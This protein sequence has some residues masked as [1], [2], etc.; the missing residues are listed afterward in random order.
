MISIS[1]SKNIPSLFL[2]LIATVTFVLPV[3]AVA[4]DGV[5]EEIVVTAAKRQ[6]TLQEVP[7][8]VA[9]VAGEDIEKAQILDL[10]DLQ[11][12]VP[13]LKINTLQNS[14]NTNFFIRGFGNGANNPGIEPSVGVF[15]DG[16]YRSRS[17]AQIADLP[18]LERVEVL[19]GPQSTLF[20][21][22]ASAGVISVVTNTPSGEF[23]AK[24]S[25]TVGN[26]NQVSLK[27]VV[28]GGLT[29]NVA[30]ELSGSSNTRDGYVD[31]LVTGNELNDRDRQ[32]VR[33]QLAIAAGD[34][35]D[36]RIIADYDQ[37]EEKCCAVNNFFT[38][39]LE[40]FTNAVTGATINEND[41]LALTTYHNLD[42]NNEIENAGLSLQLDHD[43][44][45][46]TLTSISAFR[47]VDSG[48]VIDADFTAADYITNLI[49]TEIDT[50]T[51]ELRLAS[52]G[53]CEVDWM[54]GAYFFD[55]SIDY[56]NDLQ[57]GPQF[58]G[59]AD[60]LTAAGGSPN[61]LAGLETAL[62]L[63]VGQAFFPANGNVREVATMD[64]QAISLFGQ[65]DW[66]ISDQLTATLGMNYTEDEKE[67]TLA[68][69]D[70]DLFSSLDLVQIG[71]GAI[72]Q[73]LVAMGV[74]PAT[75]LA[76]AQALSTTPANPLLG[77]QPLQFLP[78]LQAYPN[79]VENGE[80]N[81]DELTYTARLA[82]DVNDSLNVYASYATG[83]KASSI[84]LSRDARPTA[85]DLAALQAAG[86]A[87]PNINSG[88]RFAS[89]EEATVI[90][91]G[92]KARLDRLSLNLA[93]FEQNI[94]NFQSNVFNGTGFNLANA[95]EQSTK[96]FEFDAT[97]YATDSLR[98]TFAGIL[99]DPVYDT[100]TAS[101][102]GDISG[103]TPAGIHETSLSLAATYDFEL[104]NG[105]TGFVSGD[106]QYEDKIPTNE[107]IPITI[108]SEE[109]NLLNLRVGFASQNG[110]AISLWGR[111]V[112]D[113]ETATTA[114]PTVAGTGGNF[115]YRS[116]PQTYG[117][118]ISKEF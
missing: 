8:A 95:E 91:L 13:S 98:I 69:V 107:G 33:G 56:S 29:D 64:N 48:Y 92:V 115:G 62:G 117:I 84:N 79:S 118:S 17:A 14:V 1:N 70:Q 43:F 104:S 100:F 24:A 81:D 40:T 71:A 105:W 93:I 94:E 2:S 59:L 90:E 12:L 30:F 37:L 111:N 65:L 41:P 16:V 42:P 6:S 113:D 109:F 27:G 68:Q 114:F 11:S 61:A 110:L 99:L 21:K 10:K 78:P 9:V 15:I 75:A 46:V 25:L 49:D 74:P 58:R 54:V 28:E 44:E 102:V 80:T 88:T 7:I 112:T 32:A 20:G 57:Y 67:A 38:S 108:S 60:A 47:T 18:N 34:N 35:T 82:Y 50:F 5:I 85:S 73:Q 63:P 87:V 26:Y 76:Q 106:Y 77:L 89:P 45:N 53:V 51:Q 116:Q 22:N 103:T 66:H 86:L 39:P 23:G 31:N 55:E 3:S 19:K 4:Q 36:I 96:G 52:N 101:T 97:F 72:F 83:F